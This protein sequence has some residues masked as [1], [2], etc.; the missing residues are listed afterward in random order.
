MESFNINL[1]LNDTHEE[2]LVI[3]DE[4]TE[5]SIFHLVKN[6]HE[7]CKLSYTDTSL[8]ELMENANLKPEEVEELGRK[9]EE[10]YF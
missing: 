1:K 10:H 9:I 6:G 4:C 5:K 2:V 3:P 8:W 7:L